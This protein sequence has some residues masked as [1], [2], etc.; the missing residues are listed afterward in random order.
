MRKVYPTQVAIHVAKTIRLLVLL[1]MTSTRAVI[2]DTPIFIEARTSHL[3]R[4]QKTRFTSG[5]VKAELL[6][7]PGTGL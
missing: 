2:L 3:Q 6:V 4:L 1:A 5:I 7:Y